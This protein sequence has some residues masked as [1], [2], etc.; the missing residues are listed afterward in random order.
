MKN[1][2]SLCALLLFISCQNDEMQNEEN[3]SASIAKIANQ[4]KMAE[5]PT[6]KMSRTKAIKLAMV[7]ALAGAGASGFA[8]A[9]SVILAPYITLWGGFRVIRCRT[10]FEAEDQCTCSSCK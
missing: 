6:H 10:L 8:G 2:I 3:I 9:S 5:T 4:Y 7:D 1:F